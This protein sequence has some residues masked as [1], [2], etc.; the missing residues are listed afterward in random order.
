MVDFYPSIS[1]ELV[2]KSLKFAGNYTTVSTE[3]LS[4]IKNACKSV[5][6]EQANLWR[7]KRV[8]NN[9]SLFDL[10]QGSIMGAELCELAGL[11]LLDGF[12]NIFGL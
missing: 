6:C 7:K 5:L 8:N 12:K 4:L 3:D 9:S 11:F 1:E 10:A 2:I